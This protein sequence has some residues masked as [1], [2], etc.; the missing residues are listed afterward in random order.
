MIFATDLD[1]TLIYAER[2]LQGYNKE[3]LPIEVIKERPISY[4]SAQ[5]LRL[6]KELDKVATVIPITTRNREEYKRISIWGEHIKPQI[7]VVNNGGT[8]FIEGKEDTIWNEKIN[9]QISALS[10]SYENALKLFLSLYKGSIKGYKKSDELI[11]LILGDKNHI[12]WE[13]VSHFQRQVEGAG[14]RID[15]HG[16]KIY[17]YPICIRKWEALRYIKMNYL[18][19]QVLAAGDSLLDAE[20]IYHADFGAVPKGAAIEETCG[21]NIY[22]THQE[23]IGAAEDI[24]CYAL[25][26][27][28]GSKIAFR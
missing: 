6:L 23:G 10:L 18:N 4:I 20:M 24:L 16:R 8:I 1:R 11:W 7:Y 15:V 27:V 9:K 22:C 28:E 14:W 13:A 26:K 19:D 17:L 5:A 3:T 2:F 21:V 25:K 12:D